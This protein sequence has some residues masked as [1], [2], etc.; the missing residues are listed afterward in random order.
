MG[1]IVAYTPLVWGRYIE[2]FAD[3]PHKNISNFTMTGYG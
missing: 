3:L 1:A 2:I